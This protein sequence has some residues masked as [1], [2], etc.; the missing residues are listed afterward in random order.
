[1]TNLAADQPFRLSLFVVGCH[2]FSPSRGPSAAHDLAW[3][4]AISS[5]SPNLRAVD[6]APCDRRL[7][8]GPS[9]NWSQGWVLKMGRATHGIAPVTTPVVAPGSTLACAV[10]P[11]FSS[12]PSWQSNA[13]ARHGGRRVALTMRAGQLR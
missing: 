3:S 4:S 10:R 1:M 12:E 11:V 2:C 8:Q 13:P 5:V 7:A 9:E 6:G